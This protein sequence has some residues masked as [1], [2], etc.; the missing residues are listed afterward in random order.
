M[1]VFLVN[2]RLAAT[3]G[4]GSSRKPQP[5]TSNPSTY[6][7]LVTSEPEPQEAKCAKDALRRD[8]SRCPP[9]PTFDCC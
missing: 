7:W 1:A 6:L 2:A 5:S 4:R 8:K 3:R 9:R